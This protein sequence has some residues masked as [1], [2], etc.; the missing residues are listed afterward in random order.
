MEA[1]KGGG[2]KSAMN[3]WAW[4]MIAFKPQ[5]FTTAKE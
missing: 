4:A 5:L 2:D 1:I 3:N